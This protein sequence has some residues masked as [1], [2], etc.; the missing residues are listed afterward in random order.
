MANGENG[1]NGARAQSHVSKE[2]NREH[3]SATHL[4]HNMAEANAKET[5]VNFK[6]A[7]DMSRAQVS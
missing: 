4:R 3:V 1:A 2:N 6:I 7:T 5:Q